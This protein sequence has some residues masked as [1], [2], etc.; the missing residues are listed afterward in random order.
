MAFGRGSELVPQV[1]TLRSHTVVA[2]KTNE[3]RFRCYARPSEFECEGPLRSQD[4]RECL[5]DIFTSDQ[6]WE[7]FGINDEVQV[8]ISSNCMSSLLTDKF[9]HSPI[10]SRGPTSTS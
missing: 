8:H 4:H 6:L 3:L 10:D 9:S 1:R 5:L 7:S 2:V